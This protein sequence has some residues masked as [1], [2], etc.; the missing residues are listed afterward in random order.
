MTDAP[1]AIEITDPNNV[2]VTFVNQVIGSGHLNSVINITLGTARF[3]P[4]S[5]EIDVDMIVSSRL[6]MDLVCAQQLYDN[7]GE[8]IKKASVSVDTKLN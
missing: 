3:S 7:L 4:K 5:G 6:R 1:S 2:P 8:L